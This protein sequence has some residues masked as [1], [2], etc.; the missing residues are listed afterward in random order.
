[1][2]RRIVTETGVAM[3]PNPNGP[4]DRIVPV[5]RIESPSGELLALLFG[6]ACHNTTLTGAHN[7]IS[8]DYAGYAQKYLGERHPGSV[9]LFLSGC[10]ADANP[11]PR[12]TLSLAVEHGRALADQVDAVLTRKMIPV[13]SSLRTKCQWVDL[14][15]K[16]LSLEEVEAYSKMN[17]SQSL[18]ARQM[19]RLHQLGGE[20]PEHYR[21]P[22]ALWHF[23]DQLDLVA[24]PAEPVAEYAH[25]IRDRLGS[26]RTW[27][28]GYS[29][30][31]FGYL[32]SA[33]IAVE[34]GHEAIGITLWIWGKH[35]FDQVG[36]FPPEVENL[37]LDTVTDLAER[38]D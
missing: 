28:A 15:L 29:N 21:A 17:S 11:D 2:N 18:M 6:C 23:G 9:C 22:F 12:G 33:R 35:L 20:L 3:G 38:I 4:V 26:S 24:L 36:F 14:P 13:S 16:R 19:L 27:V 8:G 30:D 10:G 34:G 7:L 25:K 5:M 32:P 37:V 31:C 1:M